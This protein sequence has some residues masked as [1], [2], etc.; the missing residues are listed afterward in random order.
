[1]SDVEEKLTMRLE[2]RI[3]SMMDVGTQMAILLKSVQNEMAMQYAGKEIPE[4][5]KRFS[6]V[7]KEL[8]GRWAVEMNMKDLA[9]KGG[10]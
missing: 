5:L 3:L 9:P 7:S 1:M 6:N 2:L 4:D 10:I 8:L